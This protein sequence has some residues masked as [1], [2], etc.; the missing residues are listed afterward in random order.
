MPAD[1][2]TTH[3]EAFVDAVR[4]GPPVLT[5]PPS[6]RRQVELNR[7]T[8]RS[9]VER[10]PVRLPFKPGDPFCRID[11]GRTEDLAGATTWVANNQRD[12]AGGGRIDGLVAPE[13]ASHRRE[14]DGTVGNAGEVGRIASAAA[15][16]GDRACHVAAGRVD[17]GVQLVRSLDDG[18]GH[19]ETGAGQLSEADE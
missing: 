19:L 3:Y 18:A 12:G 7:A 6:L 2:A 13:A 16:H 9:L 15:E 10:R 17:Q 1:G 4:G 14:R 5:S 11:E 8:A